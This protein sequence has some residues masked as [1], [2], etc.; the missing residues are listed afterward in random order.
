MGFK[1]NLVFQVRE[2]RSCL[3]VF[4]KDL[5]DTLELS[6]HVRENEGGWDVECKWRN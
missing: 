4:E 5:V 3:R 1:K 2:T 6:L